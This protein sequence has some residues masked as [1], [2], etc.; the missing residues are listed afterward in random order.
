MVF[1]QI[2]LK[3]GIGTD[4]ERRLKETFRNIFLL[5]ID[6]KS[7]ISD[8]VLGRVETTAKVVAHN[9]LNKKALFGGIPVIFLVGDGY[10]LPPAKIGA[11][12]NIS[13]DVVRENN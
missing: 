1:F 2:D 10:Q 11:P 12:E 8:D 5:V 9:G 6:E 4:K 7:M 13:N 3:K